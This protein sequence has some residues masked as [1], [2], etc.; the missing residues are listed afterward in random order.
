MAID[1][2]GTGYSTLT[3]LRRVNADLLKIDQSLVRGAAHTDPDGVILEGIVHI[4]RGLGIEVLAE[5][6]ET[7]EEMRTLIDRGC[8]Q[9][10]GYL[11]SKPIARN[12][13]ETFAS[14]PNASWRI[15]ITDPESWRPPETE[16]SPQPST[17]SPSK[18]PRE[19]YARYDED[20]DAELYPVLKDG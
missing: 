2:F 9:M 18:E 12:E 5:G 4:A 15:A 16:T 11:F 6:G 20:P 13:I 17:A 1:D 10:Q 14:D 8:S 19:L 3:L 7:I